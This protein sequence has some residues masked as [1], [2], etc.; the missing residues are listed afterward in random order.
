MPRAEAV[1]TANGLEVKVHPAGA[2][3]AGAQRFRWVGETLE[4]VR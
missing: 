4:D 1:S 3:D 2:S